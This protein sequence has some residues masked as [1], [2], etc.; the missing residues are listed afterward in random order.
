M[1]PFRQQAFQA[2]K[3]FNNIPRSA[4]PIKQYK[5]PDRVNPEKNLRVWDYANNDGKRISIRQDLSRKYGNGGKGDQG[6]HHKAGKTGGKL[7]QHYYFNKLNS[8]G[9]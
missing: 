2:A 1:N 7:K 8:K 9:G 6:H 4:Q 3:R 5:V